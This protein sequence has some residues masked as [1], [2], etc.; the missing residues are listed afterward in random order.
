MKTSYFLILLTLLVTHWPSQTIAQES[1]V[2]AVQPNKCVALRKGQKCY[3]KLNITF[4][5]SEPRDYCLYLEGNQIPIKCWINAR[6]GNLN[7]AL[8]SENS[9]QFILQNASGELMAVSQVTVAW[10][11]SKRTRRK[12]SWRLF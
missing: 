3:Q 2:L 8:N 4:K 1:A 11:Y 9:V 6:Q 7:Y 5:A 10:V 12:S